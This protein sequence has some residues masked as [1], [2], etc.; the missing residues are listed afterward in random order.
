MR[1]NRIPIHRHKYLN[2]NTVCHKQQNMYWQ[3]A[4]DNCQSCFLYRHLD[5]KSLTTSA[6]TTNRTRVLLIFDNFYRYTEHILQ[7]CKTL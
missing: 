4:R 6:L 7:Y 2:R 3:V 5:V 1:R